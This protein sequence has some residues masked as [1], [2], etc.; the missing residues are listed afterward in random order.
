MKFFINWVSFNKKIVKYNVFNIKQ[1]KKK[2]IKKYL[3]KV[4]VTIKIQVNKNFFNK[5]LKN[6]KLLKR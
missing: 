3:I 6:N 1:K 2:K 5:N 4:I